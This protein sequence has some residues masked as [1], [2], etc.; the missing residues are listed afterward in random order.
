MGG[1][2]LTTDEV[3][4]GGGIKQCSDGSTHK[5]GKKTYQVTVKAFEKI[6][7]EHETCYSALL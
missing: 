5:R 4:S 2:C 3:L 6:K 7:T 1:F